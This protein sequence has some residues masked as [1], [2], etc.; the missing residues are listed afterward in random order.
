MFSSHPKQGENALKVQIKSQVRNTAEG[1]SIS[2]TCCFK[3]NCANTD[4]IEGLK[5]CSR[6]WLDAAM[7]QG[8]DGKAMLHKR[9]GTLVHRQCT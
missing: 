6:Y 9:I 4:C 8:G 7:L 1:A 5:A 2:V 3:I